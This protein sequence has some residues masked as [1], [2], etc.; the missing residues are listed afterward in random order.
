[1]AD[2]T[3]LSRRDGEQLLRR[4]APPT[5]AEQ[6]AN[7]AG[8]AEE[9]AEI[10]RLIKKHGRKSGYERVVATQK[11]FLAMLHLNHPNNRR[12]NPKRVRWWH[13][14]YQD[15]RWFDLDAFYFDWDGFM[16]NGQ[17]RAMAFAAINAIKMPI[18]IKFGIDPAAALATDIN[19]VRTP[20]QNLKN[21]GVSGAGVVS[22]I[23]SFQHRI[24][25]GGQI[26]D[27]HL[28]ERIGEEIGFEE[29]TARALVCSQKLYKSF[30][31]PQSASAY[32]Y[33][34][35]VLHS[36]RKLSVDEFWDALWPPRNSTAAPGSPIAIL[37]DRLHREQTADR[38]KRG[39]YKFQTQQAAW[40]ILGWNAWVNDERP[41]FRWEKEHELPPIDAK[42]GG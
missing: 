31:T 30:H 16:F 32:V 12:A 15:G 3:V 9:L 8:F 25:T 42:R 41:S 39:Q 26:A 1:M 24:A 5:I 36:R 18:D 40:I 17:H 33:R 22:A 14:A 20:A 2:N 4:L 29:L 19:M 34:Q 27:P 37:R 21:R 28:A 35:I 7:P 13:D 10:R 23:A 6:L 11:F 38:K